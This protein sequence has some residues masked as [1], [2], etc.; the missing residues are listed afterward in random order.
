LTSLATLKTALKLLSDPTRLRLLAL[1]A[2]EELA[3]QELVTITGLA[4]SR[5][6]NHLAL[7]K[8]A[9][10]VRDRRE[11]SWSFHSLVEPAPGRALTPELFEAVVRPFQE[12]EE[13][14]ADAHALEVVREQRREQ[15]RRTHDALADHWVELGQEFRGGGLRAEALSALVPSDLTVA[16]LGCGA[17]YLTAYLAERVGRVIAVD[18]SARMLEA[19]E[20]QIRATPERVTFRRGELEQL[21]LADGE[22]DAAFANLVFHHVADMDRAARE[23]LRVLRPGGRVV[24]TDLE[25]HDEDWM[26][27]AMGDLRLGVRAE[28]VVAALARA[29]FVELEQRRLE[30][31]YRVEAPDGRAAHLP[32]FL[33]RA[34]RPSLP[35]TPIP[36][37][38]S[39]VQER[40]TTR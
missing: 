24:I 39:P 30:D 32:M 29:G 28:T 38:P 12:S 40:S 11:G 2:S 35:E 17:G 6:S 3:V 10:I 19:A 9:G 27:E 18:H 36:R 33:V 25:P 8:R 37:E 20:R 15:S 31:S 14:R 7:L 16:D 4:Q 23:V 22:V 21:P 1:L 26:R 13:G 5:V 34:R